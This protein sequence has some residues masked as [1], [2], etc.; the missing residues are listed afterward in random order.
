MKCPQEKIVAGFVFADSEY[1]LRFSDSNI[2]FTYSHAHHIVPQAESV[3][4][5]SGAHA[6]DGGACNQLKLATS[7]G[8]THVCKFSSEHLREIECVVSF[9]A[10]C[11][12]LQN[13]DLINYV[14][15]IKIINRIGGLVVKLA[16]AI[17]LNQFG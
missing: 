4:I 16:V 10:E 14:D 12:G 13:M 1:L 8:P 3:E 15:S 17:H 2:M 9:K 7:A 11:V 5:S 6:E